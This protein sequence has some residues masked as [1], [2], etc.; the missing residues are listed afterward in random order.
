MKKNESTFSQYSI[1]NDDRP[2]AF[3]NLFKRGENMT[4][5]KHS[6]ITFFPS[7]DT[8]YFRWKGKEKL[9]NLLGHFF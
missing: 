1:E 6:R 2:F 4:L 5:G 7:F 9:M 8:V 3:K